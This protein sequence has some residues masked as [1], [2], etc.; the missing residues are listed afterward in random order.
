[1]RK[2]LEEDKRLRQLAAETGGVSTKSL[3]AV[4]RHATADEFIVS[5]E[6]KKRHREVV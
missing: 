3:S 4:G 5:L 6:E 2:T 1:M